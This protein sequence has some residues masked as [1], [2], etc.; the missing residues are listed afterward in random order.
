MT[1]FDNIQTK[2]SAIRIHSEHHKFEYSNHDIV[3]SFVKHKD[4]NIKKTGLCL[5]LYSVIS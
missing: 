2:Q 5:V 1:T 4:Q 3:A